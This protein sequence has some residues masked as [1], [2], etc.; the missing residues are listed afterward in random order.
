MENAERCLP[1]LRRTPAHN[2][3]GTRQLLLFWRFLDLLNRRF[4]R[5]RNRNRLPDVLPFS[6]HRVCLFSCLCYP[7]GYP[8]RFTSWPGHLSPVSR[9]FPRFFR[10]C[11][12]SEPGSI[13]PSTASA[14]RFLLVRSRHL[15]GSP[16][17]FF[18]FSYGLL[19]PC[20]CEAPQTGTFRSTSF[21]RT[22]F[23]P[24]I[25]I[26]RTSKR[27]EPAVLGSG[28]EALVPVNLSRWT[29]DSISSCR[30]PVADATVHLFHQKLAVRLWHFALFWNSPD[31]IERPP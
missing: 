3:R 29:A 10:L 23:P 2:T 12:C 19:K 26:R 28:G 15:A 1:L 18:S 14:I 8:F 9:L 24:E 7:L 16:S 27:Q 31:V 13:H 6:N 25:C 30:Y 20:L 4:S 17:D 11:S 22:S 5:W 21:R